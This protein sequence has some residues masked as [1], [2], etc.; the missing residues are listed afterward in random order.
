[1]NRFVPV[2]RRMK[3]KPGTFVLLMFMTILILVSLPGKGVSEELVIVGTGAGMPVLKAVGKAF[4]ERNPEI[5]V[6]IPKSIGTGGGIKAVGNDEFSLGRIARDISDME[7]KYGLTQLPMAKL[8]IVFYVNS[9]V[10]LVDITPEQACNIYS[11]TVRTWEE[12]GGGKGTIRVIT[13]ESG[14]SSLTVLLN[15]LPGFKAINQ[16]LISKTTYTDQETIES[17]VHQENSIA[18]G[19]LSDAKEI[20]GIRVLNLD[21]LSPHDPNY[22]LFSPLDLVYKEKNYKGSLKKFIEFISSDAAKKAIIDAGG[23]VVK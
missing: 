8:P 9:R 3:L 17:C 18:Y 4:T 22:P 7:K 15:T 21:G 23:L 16:T 1:M 6:T 14:D 20:S 12:L 10:F 2:R 13:R 5:I 11:G 19:T